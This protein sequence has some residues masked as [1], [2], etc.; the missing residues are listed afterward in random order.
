MEREGGEREIE[1]VKAHLHPEGVSL[2]LWLRRRRTRAHKVSRRRALP[3]LALELMSVCQTRHVVRC[4][5]NPSSM[6]MINDQWELAPACYFFLITYSRC[7]LGDSSRGF[8]ECMDTDCKKGGWSPVSYSKV[9]EF[10]GAIL[11]VSCACSWCVA[12][13]NL[14]VIN[15]PI[16]DVCTLA[17]VCTHAQRYQ[18]A[19]GL[20][21]RVATRVVLDRLASAAARLLDRDAVLIDRPLLFRLL[22]SMSPLNI[23]TN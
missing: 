23:C 1:R 6:G 8:S 22:G 2:E 18:S 17:R 20:R 4:G 19:R 14:N 13:T 3:S 5:V 21:S 10:A 7:H 9:V 12:A 15:A 16:I 11:R